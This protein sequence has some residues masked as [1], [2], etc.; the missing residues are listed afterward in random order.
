MSIL[1]KFLQINTFSFTIATDSSLN[2][3]YYIPFSL[4][5]EDYWN[6]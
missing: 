3:S 1:S 2:L 4:Q 5:S 6:I